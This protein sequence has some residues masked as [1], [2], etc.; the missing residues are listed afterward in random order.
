[1]RDCQKRLRLTIL[2]GCQTAGRPVKASMS[3]SAIRSKRCISMSNE[4]LS[5]Q[6]PASLDLVSLNSNRIRAR[7]KLLLR[8]W[9]LS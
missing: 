4:I 6:L 3:N 7:S 1:M 9:L 8:H 2:I 5:T